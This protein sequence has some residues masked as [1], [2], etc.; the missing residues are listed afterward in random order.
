MV[1]L[2][3]KKKLGGE[4]SFAPVG[5]GDYSS[6]LP[7][8]LA[9]EKQASP[10]SAGEE[11]LS[12]LKKDKKFSKLFSKI[13][14]AK[15]G[16]INFYLADEV[17]REELQEVLKKGEKYGSA[18]NGKGRKINIEFVSANPTGPLTLGNGRSAAYGES[19]ARLLNF[20]GH[21]VTKEYFLNDLGRQVAL[22]GESVA[23]RFLEL[24]GR[25]TDY[26]EEMYQG[27]YILDIAKKFKE[28]GAYHGSL[29]DFESLIKS[30][31]KYAVEK[32]TASLKDSLARFG[33]KHDVWFPESEL[34][35]HGEIDKILHD[36]NINNLSYEKD[37]ALW[38][39]S[40]D[41]G[42]DSDAVIKKSNGFTTYLLSDFAYAKNKLK[43]GFD[44]MIYI[45]GADHHADVARIKSGLRAMKLPE[46]KFRFLLYQLVTLVE[47]GEQVRMSKRAGRF[48]TLD[49]LVKE[50]PADVVK[51]FFLAKSMD[52]HVEFDLDLAKEESNKNPVYYIQYAFVRMQ[53]ILR[54]AKGIG[55]KTEK[56]LSKVYPWKEEE[57][58]LVKELIKFPEILAETGE[59]YQIHHLTAY[60]LDLAGKI[61]RFY[62][63][64]KVIGAEKELEKFR[65]TLV[66]ASAIVLRNGLT[67]LG[68]SLPEKM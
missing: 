50:V 14:L 36:F 6:N 24:N 60:I 25:Q 7:L 12:D 15:P 44:K 37:G 66:Q 59:N 13:E 8:V 4:V 27:E 63:T 1:K 40:S 52:S 17:L 57:E 11:I 61:N 21:K 54:K 56:K 41:F 30:A 16:F 22:L 38:F 68:I 55:I 67:L 10:M 58:E 43:R 35:N 32:I 42:L 29:D 9:G 3:I 47:K 48:V 2:E 65:L 18:K 51:F 45:L 26:P 28:D 53:S 19:L 23:R 46:E 64:Q 39:K 62:E 31:Q 34:E 5:F 49:E 33:V 20:L